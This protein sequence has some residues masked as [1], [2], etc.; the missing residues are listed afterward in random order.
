MMPAVGGKTGDLQIEVILIRP[1]PW[2]GVEAAMAAQHVL[3]GNRRL[4][5]RGAPGFEPHAAIAIEAVRKGTAIARRIDVGIAAA[6]LAVASDAI[7]DRKPG[8]LGK[9]DGRCCTNAGDHDIGRNAPSIGEQN[10]IIFDM[11]DA[12]AGENDDARRGMAIGDAV[13]MASVTPRNRMRGWLSMTVTAQPRWLALAASS[14]PM[15]PPPMIATLRPGCACGA[16]RDQFMKIPQHQDPLGP[17][18]RQ[19]ARPRTGGDQQLLVGDAPSI[20]Q[21]HRLGGTIDKGRHCTRNERDIE[22]VQQFLVEQEN[23]RWLLHR[24]HRRFRQWRAIIGRMRLFADQ[25]DQRPS[26]H[27][28]AGSP[29]RGRPPCRRR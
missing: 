14:R 23:R 19:A 24:G 17:W 6:H 5:L 13:A 12:G 25:G 8:R 28:R 22:R 16:Q 9:R 10:C 2:H 7:V 3:G 4:V 11:R 15:T 29:R 27:A 1:E 21:Q 26:S 20:G 18:E